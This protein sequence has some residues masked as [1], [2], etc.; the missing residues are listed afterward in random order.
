MNILHR[1]GKIKSPG[2]G[3]F[4]AIQQIRRRTGNEDDRTEIQMEKLEN[5]LREKKPEA[6]RQ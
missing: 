2:G 1:L 5:D 4:G 3:N 6:R